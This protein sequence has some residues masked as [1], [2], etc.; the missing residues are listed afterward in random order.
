[1]QANGAKVNKQGVKRRG[2]KR[3]VGRGG[4]AQGAGVPE[5]VLCSGLEV[6]EM[7]SFVTYGFGLFSEGQGTKCSQDG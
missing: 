4:L 2:R 1:M 7:R 3:E 5:Q 6:P